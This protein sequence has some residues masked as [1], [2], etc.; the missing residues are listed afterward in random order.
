M[1]LADEGMS[2]YRMQAVGRQSSWV[3]DREQMLRGYVMSYRKLFRLLEGG[4]RGFG[5]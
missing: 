3:Q 1:I 2:R 4:G 5:M